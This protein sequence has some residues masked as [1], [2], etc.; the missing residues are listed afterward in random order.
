[1][2]EPS[3]AEWLRGALPFLALLTLRD[4]ALHGYAI[5]QRL[6]ELSLFGL[7]VG[8][9]YPVLNRLESQELVRAE[10]VAGDGGPGRK[11]YGLTDAGRTRLD[12]MSDAWGDFAS[13]MAAAIAPTTTRS[14]R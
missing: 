4:G 13:R 10:W 1:M 7:K 9:L 6:E 12:S 2:S 11:Q 8:T 14:T 5:A 3:E